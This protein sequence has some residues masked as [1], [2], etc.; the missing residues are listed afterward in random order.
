MRLVYCTVASLS[1]LGSYPSFTS[2]VPNAMPKWSDASCKVNAR[3]ATAIR[4]AV[5]S[6]LRAAGMAPLLPDDPTVV[7]LSCSDPRTP[8][9][10][11]T[12]FPESLSSEPRRIGPQGDALLRV[13]E[14]SH[15]LKTSPPLHT[16]P[17]VWDDGH[18]YRNGQRGNTSHCVSQASRWSVHSPQSTRPQRTLPTAM[19]SADNG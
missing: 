4:M 19:K 8:D 10:R 17:F 12:R 18:Y 15:T 2:K 9:N 7:K 1:L 3:V 6:T 14:R 16:D 13:A 5:Q 11:V